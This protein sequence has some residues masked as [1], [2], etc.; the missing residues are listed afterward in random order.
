MTD[1]D[2]KFTEMYKLRR[3]APHETA[4]PS[5]FVVDMHGVVQFAKVSHSH[6]D[7]ASGGELLE[8]ADETEQL[9]CC[10]RDVSDPGRPRPNAG[11]P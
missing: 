3:N 4:Y 10:V 6:G 8:V 9:G 7:R 2:F 5:S 11:T 1:P